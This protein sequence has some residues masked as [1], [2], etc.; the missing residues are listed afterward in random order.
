MRPN[1]PQP[2]PELRGGRGRR[3]G[4]WSTL[5]PEKTCQRHQPN[6]RHGAEP[7]RQIAKSLSRK[8]VPSPGRNGC[9]GGGA[10]GLK[11]SAGVILSPRVSETQRKYQVGDVARE[12]VKAIGE[13][14]VEDVETRQ[15]A[16]RA[17]DAGAPVFDLQEQLGKR[18]CSGSRKPWTTCGASPRKGG[19]RSGG[20]DY[21]RG[22]GP[23]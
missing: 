22:Q 21:G 9:Q 10:P 13:F 3:P 23:G 5:M 18:C 16:A 14:L 2:K 8:G 17:A 11:P 6:L 4:P 15:E 12:N 20:P 19:A 7:A 1:H